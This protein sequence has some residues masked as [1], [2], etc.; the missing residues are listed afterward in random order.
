[1][2]ELS[3]YLAELPEPQRSAIAAV[4]QRARALVPDAVEME[5]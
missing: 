5:R 1:M 4:Y 2:S 3:D